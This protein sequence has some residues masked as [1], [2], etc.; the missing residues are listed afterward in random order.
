MRKSNLMKCVGVIFIFLTMMF[1]C[2]PVSEYFNENGGNNQ[3]KNGSSN[4]NKTLALGGVGVYSYTLNIE[5]IKKILTNY[6]Y[7][8]IF[9]LTDNHL[10]KLSEYG[11]SEWGFS[12]ASKDEAIYHIYNYGYMKANITSSGNYAVFGGYAVNDNFQYYDGVAVGINETSFNVI[13]DMTKLANVDLISYLN[14]EEVSVTDKNIVLLNGY[15]PYI[16]GWELGESDSDDYIMWLDKINEGL[17]KM[18]AGASF[19]ISLKKDVSWA[20][21]YKD[22]THCYVNIDLGTFIELKNN[23]FTFI[24]PEFDYSFFFTNGNW[25]ES[26]PIS[27]FF[28]GGAVIDEVDKEFKLS[29]KQND[30]N[31]TII[32]FKP[33][34]LTVGKMYMVTL[35]VKSECEAYVKVNEVKTTAIS[36]SSKNH[37][38]SYCIGD[39]IDVTNLTVEATTTKGSKLT[40]D[41]MPDMISGFD[42]SKLGKQTLTI[43]LGGCKVTY[44]VEIKDIVVNEIDVTSNK[45]VDIINELNDGEYYLIRVSGEMTDNIMDCILEIIGSEYDGECAWITL[46]LSNTTGLTSI[47]GFYNCYGL[48]GIMIPNGVTSIGYFHDC[49]NLTSITIPDSVV[50][51][52]DGAFKGDSSL[53]TFNIGINNENYSSSDDGKILFNKDKT[54]LIAYPSATG[55]VIIPA[56]VISIANNAF[57]SCENL[58]SVTIP[59][60]VVDIS[61]GAFKGDSSL[62]TFNIGINNENYSL[63]DDGKILFNKDK[64]ELI[65]YPSAAGDVI[66]P[67]GVTAIRY[68]VFSYCEDLVSITIPDSL[69]S[70]DCGLLYGCNNLTSVTFEN[71]NN[72]YYSDYS[73]N[74]NGTEIDVTDTEQN[75][76][77][78]KDIYCFYY[79][80]RVEEGIYVSGLN[81]VNCAV[82]ESVGSA[83]YMTEGKDDV[84][85]FTFIADSVNPFP[86]GFKFTTEKGTQEE[87]QA[88]NADNSA[89]NIVILSPDKEVDIYYKDDSVMVDDEDLTK[90]YVKMAFIAGYEY[91][92]TFDKVN[93]KIKITGEF[94]KITADNVC[95]YI[96]EFQVGTHTIKVTGEINVNTLYSISSAINSTEAEIILDLSETTGLTEVPESTFKGCGLLGILLPN[97]ITTIGDNAFN[98]CYNL[99]SIEI[100]DSVT[101]IGNNVFNR[102]ENL[103]SV[104]IPNKVAYI[105]VKTFAYCTSLTEVIFEDVNNWYCTGDKEI[106]VTDSELNVYNF[107]VYCNDY[108]YKE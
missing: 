50:D 48:K 13:V 78:L 38:T 10:K 30:F 105:G 82:E 29:E 18:E 85:T 15:K 58:I 26:N 72:W 32:R 63:S 37:K 28:V 52:S 23:L 17:F 22:V 9:L 33:G 95:D 97:G 100:P 3:G 98:G 90:F 62:T 102:C 42:S 67:A 66:I 107:T 51:I 4:K 75:A 59:D 77:Y 34:V 6:P 60:S 1:S 12:Q 89:A 21:T 87:Y 76:N 11:T 104:I 99:T 81:G 27:R 39:Y 94:E 88:Y 64:T 43:T 74:L 45:V 106:N 41:V 84:Y 79:W 5:D 47:D 44:D 69:T 71:T 55:D 61:D 40:V 2:Q 101:H 49:I 36:I 83:N 24:A 54:E 56:G 86:D 53:T 80:Y 7:F 93:M 65:A 103:T 73:G 20:P 46:D 96:Y 16:V 57:E 92:I 19:P 70:I 91:T 108:L 25:S 8:S 14:G 68:N 35:I 31:E